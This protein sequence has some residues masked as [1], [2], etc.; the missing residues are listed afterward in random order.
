MAIPVEG[1]LGAGAFSPRKLPLMYK[2]FSAVKEEESQLW[3]YENSAAAAAAA[4]LGLGVAIGGI[5][6]GFLGA[7]RGSTAACQRCL[8][9]GWR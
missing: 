7:K 3:Q 6:G 5:P 9:I 8:C 2:T 4:M 1:V